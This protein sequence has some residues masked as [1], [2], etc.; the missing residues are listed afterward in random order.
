MR[1]LITMWRHTK[2]PVAPGLTKGHRRTGGAE[3]E[4]FDA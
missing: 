1:E 3:S 4:R 2:M